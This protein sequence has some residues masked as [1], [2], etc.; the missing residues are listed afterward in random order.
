MLQYLQQF[1]W[2]LL[3]NVSGKYGKLNYKEKYSHK[4]YSK[5]I[6]EPVLLVFVHEK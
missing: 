2:D 1:R 3:G 4:K 6:N 5:V